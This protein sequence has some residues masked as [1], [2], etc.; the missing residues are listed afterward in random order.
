MVENCRLKVP[1]F[2]SCFFLARGTKN[3]PYRFVRHT[4]VSRY[5][6]N[7]FVFSRTRRSTYGYSSEGI[8]QVLAVLLKASNRAFH[9]GQQSGLT[10]VRASSMPVSSVTAISEM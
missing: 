2:L 4:V 5:L 6:A 1:M 8:L 3:T 7:G 10:L 9:E